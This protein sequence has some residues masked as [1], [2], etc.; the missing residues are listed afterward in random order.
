MIENQG[1]LTAANN[2]LRICKIGDVTKDISRLRL[3]PCRRPGDPNPGIGRIIS[4]IETCLTPR[5]HVIKFD[6][7]AVLIPSPE[8]TGEELPIFH[9]ETT[10]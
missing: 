1:V 8:P 10:R 5:I 4:R 3:L 6:P 7:V 9:I 2:R